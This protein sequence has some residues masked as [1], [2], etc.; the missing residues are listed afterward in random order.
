MIPKTIAIIHRAKVM[1]MMCFFLKQVS[2]FVLKCQELTSQNPTTAARSPAETWISAAITK[3]SA[4]FTELDILKNAPKE[5]IMTTIMEIMCNTTAEN[6][7]IPCCL[8]FFW[9][10]RKIALSSKPRTTIWMTKLMVDA[11]YIKVNSHLKVNWWIRCKRFS[12][13][14]SCAFSTLVGNRRDCI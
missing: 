10:F 14:T 2:K 5:G 8:Y 6:I 1:S 7:T 12:F 9:F 4:K 3:I 11:T 13:F